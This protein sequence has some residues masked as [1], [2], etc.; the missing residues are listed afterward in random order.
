[1]SGPDR[2]ELTAVR[3]ALRA[4]LAEIADPEADLTA[5]AAT[6]NRLEGAALALDVLARPPV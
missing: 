5:P 3:D 4:V 2:D 1:M 6:R